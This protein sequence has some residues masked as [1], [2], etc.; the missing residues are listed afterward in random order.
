VGAEARGSA[1][2]GRG[3]RGGKRKRAAR[4]GSEGAPR[5]SLVRRD[6]SKRAA[7][8]PRA[9]GLVPGGRGRRKPP[10]PAADFSPLSQKSQAASAPDPAPERKTTN[11]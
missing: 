6:V 8:Y 7:S 9:R 3:G 10:S 4:E 2:G 5:M 1:V 11:P